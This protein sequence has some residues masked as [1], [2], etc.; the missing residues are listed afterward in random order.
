MKQRIIKI[1][2]ELRGVI[3]Q[4]QMN[5]SD[6]VLFTQALSCYRGEL[7]GEKKSLQSPLTSKLGG[8]SGA[9]EK[10]KSFLKKLGFTGNVDTLTKLQAMDEINRRT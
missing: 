4:Q 7:V 10:Q 3:E 1:V 6:D 8:F 5:V 2:E 9:T